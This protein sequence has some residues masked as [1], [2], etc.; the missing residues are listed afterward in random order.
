MKS[1]EKMKSNSGRDGD[2]ADYVEVGEGDYC[3]ITVNRRDGSTV[4]QRFRTRKEAQAQ[5]RR[6]VAADEPMAGIEGTN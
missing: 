4:V 1:N 5:H 6:N 2:G 3:V